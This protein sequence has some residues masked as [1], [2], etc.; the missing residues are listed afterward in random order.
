MSLFD[1]D[2]LET[3]VSASAVS[4]PVTEPVVA[5]HDPY[6]ALRFRDFRLLISGNFISSIGTRML[7]VAL[8]WDLYERTGSALVLGGIGLVLVI[9]V[10][11]FSLPAGHVADR[12]NR[13][14]IIQCGQ[15]LSVLAILGLALLAYGHGSIFL[16]YGCLFLMGVANAFDGPASSALT[17]QIIPEEA[18]ENASTWSSSSWQL[19]SVM[20]PG[21][22]GII[23]ALF[24]SAGL[25]YII[26]T[27]AAL[28]FLILISLL[29]MRYQHKVVPKSEGTTWQSIV[30]GL[31]FL[32]KT[33]VI[34]AAITLDM[35]AVLLGGA[36]TLLP[37]YAKDILHVGP[38]G[39]GLLRAAPSVGA[40]CVALLLAHRPPFKHAGRTLLLSVAGFGIATIIF[41]FSQW[42]WLSIAMLF[43][44]GGLDNISVVIRGTLLLMRTPDEMRGR[45]SAVNS[46]FIG[47][48]NELGGF[49]SG[50]TAQLLGPMFSV[51]GGGIGTIIVVL[52]VALLWPEMRRLGTLRQEKPEAI[53]PVE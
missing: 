34:L 8:G 46:L 51:V 23:I 25:V 33:R 48:S 16:M 39:L 3:E 10:F 17:S 9:P 22:G 26:D 20:G 42:F 50:L 35:F 24:H 32:R 1:K 52:A 12:Y 37:I 49:E 7:E 21:L 6:F 11:L 13:K 28:F 31:S 27:I 15:L 14:R 41:G 5:T 47:A 4:P 43:C 18:F 40:V 44:L 38:T 29:Q 2:T 19:A 30:E 36:T 53:A 45:V